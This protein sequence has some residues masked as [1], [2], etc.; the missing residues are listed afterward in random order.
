V[1][2]YGIKQLQK[3][4]DQIRTDDVV[5]EKHEKFSA[6]WLRKLLIATV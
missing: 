4:C 3:A 6:D 1:C 5:L 2:P